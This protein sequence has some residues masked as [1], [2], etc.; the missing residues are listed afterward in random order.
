MIRQTLIAGAALALAAACSPSPTSAAASVAEPPAAG[1]LVNYTAAEAKPPFAPV[2]DEEADDIPSFQGLLPPDLDRVANLPASIAPPDPAQL[3]MAEHYD[4]NER[5]IA[6]I[7]EAETLQLRSYELGGLE[8][9]GYGHLMLEGEKDP[10]TEKIAEDLLR[11]DVQWCEQA[12]ERYIDVP[13]THNEFSAVSAFCYNVGSAKTRT[14]S[15]VKRL[16][17]GD[18]AGAADAFLKWTRMNGK[19]MKALAERR[20]RERTL[21]LT[22]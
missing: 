2:P 7:K 1:H 16:N 14:S 17:V 11:N 6:I 8:L 10:I 12:L 5:A 22:P 15:I 3:R 13:L 18:R 20:A 9:I 21:F 19:V 4:T